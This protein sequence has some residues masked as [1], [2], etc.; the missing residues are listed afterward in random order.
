L[1]GGKIGDNEKRTGNH[2][3][4]H[5]GRYPRPHDLPPDSHRYHQ[6]GLYGLGEVRDG[7]SKTYAL[8][9]KSRLVGE[10]PL[11]VDPAVPQDQTVFGSMPDKGAGSARWR[12]R[13]GTSW[14]NIT[15]FRYITPGGKFRA[16]SVSTPTPTC[17][18]SPGDRSAPEEADEPGLYLSEMDFMQANR[19][20]GEIH[21]LY[22][23]MALPAG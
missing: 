6:E 12:W 13:S 20:K 21:T 3:P 23:R 5:G 22:G 15:V 4:A 11:D 19:A 10:N 2:R 14:A 1:S 7:A 17:P 9:L 16:A 8:M 18:R